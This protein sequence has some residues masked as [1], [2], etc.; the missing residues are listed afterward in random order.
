MW[1]ECGLLMEDW[2]FL[3]DFF[4]DL[5]KDNVKMGEWTYL[6]G[7]EP[8]LQLSFGLSKEALLELGC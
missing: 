8:L 2:S 6:P 3:C 1:D 5:K 4:I 7:Q